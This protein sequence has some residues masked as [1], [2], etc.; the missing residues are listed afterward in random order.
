MSVVWADGLNM[1]MFMGMKE[2][3][4]LDPPLVKQLALL[5][6]SRYKV[7]LVVAGVWES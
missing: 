5:L 4:E 2:L 3:G 6:Y 7:A 1:L